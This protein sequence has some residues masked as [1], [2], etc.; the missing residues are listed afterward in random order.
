MRPQEEIR[1]ELFS[2]EHGALG[3]SKDILYEPHH[4]VRLS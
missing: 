2:T 3:R 4:S 1:I